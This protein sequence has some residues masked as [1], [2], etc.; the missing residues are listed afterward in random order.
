MDSPAYIKSFDPETGALQWTLYSTPQNPGDP[1]AETWASLDAARH[2]AGMTW[3]RVRTI[4]KRTS[5]FTAPETHARLHHRERRR[6]QPVHLLADRG[7]RR[8][9]QDGVV[10]PDSPH[11]TQTGIPPRPRSS[12]ICRSTGAL[13]SW[14]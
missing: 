10:L 11:D 5:T 3:I 14:S 9:G 6:R 7:E 2:G 1:G 4:P 13:A 12:P 8:Y